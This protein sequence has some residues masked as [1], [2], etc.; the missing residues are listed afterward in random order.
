MRRI[1]ITSLLGLMLTATGSFAADDNGAVLAPSLTAAATTLAAQ[2]DARSA[3]DFSTAKPA[4]RR[5][6][7]LPALYV[8]TAVLQ[9]YDAYS[10]LTALKQGGA[11]QN[12][13]MKNVVKS[14]V[15]FVALKVGIATASIMAAERM[16]KSNNR[17]GAIV[18]MVA[19]N[20]LMAYVAAHNASVLRSQAR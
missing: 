13:L 18:T 9:G 4:I 8:G 15:A 7:L 3:I 11:E 6:G 14:P 16:W 1:L 19:S 2:T 5:P 10:T 12:P 17:V 20:G